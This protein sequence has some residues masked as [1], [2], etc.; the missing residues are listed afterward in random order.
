M[1]LIISPIPEYACSP[2]HLGMTFTSSL[3]EFVAHVTK[4]GGSDDVPGPDLG[5]KKRGHLHLHM[6]GIQPPCYKEA[7]LETRGNEALLRRTQ[8]CFV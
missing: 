6:L 3:S 8:A 5:L 4:C 7:G 1:P 2:C